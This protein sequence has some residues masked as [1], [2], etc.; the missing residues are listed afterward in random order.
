[1]KT[2]FQEK[3]KPIF[4]QNNQFRTIM[5]YFVFPIEEKESDIGY[6]DMLP[7]ML[8]HVSRKF[9]DEKSFLKEYM[10]RY[11]DSLSI[12]ISNFGS[13]AFITAKLIIPD[14]RYLKEDHVEEAIEFMIDAIYDPKV[15]NDQFDEQ[16]FQKMKTS[17]LTSIEECP[18]NI[19]QWS[20]QKFI[21]LFDESGYLKNNIYNHKDY[22]EKITSKD[23]YQYYL[24]KIFSTKPLTFVFGNVE[25]NTIENLLNKYLYKGTYDL[26]SFEKDYLYFQETKKIKYEEDKKNFN[27]SRLMLGYKVKN[28]TEEDR[29]LLFVI[30]DLLSSQS[31]SL[32]LKKLREEQNIV[33]STSCCLFTRLGGIGIDALIHRDNREAA[34][35]GIK[36]VIQQL[37]K[38]EIIKPL[39][40]K[41]KERN[42]LNLL[43]SSDN[44]NSISNDYICKYLG[45]ELT[46]E[47]E[48]ERIQKV[49]VDDITKF[50]DRLELD[51][52][53]YLEGEKDGK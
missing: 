18:K 16:Q 32:L 19:Y 47:E 44:K 9:P 37:K 43:K 25:E 5:I 11:I 4:I 7:A 35:K 52:V 6:I 17:I 41:V 33:Y 49:T 15:E 8:V 36:E 20:N 3:N 14:P 22:I 53:Y 46:L 24:E 31:S 26:I 39:L 21:E 13:R 27:Q 10:R 28:M 38:K 1:M 34:E 48:N 2:L 50:I 45:V 12:N 51:T 42:Y 30:S 29:I 40:E 23:L